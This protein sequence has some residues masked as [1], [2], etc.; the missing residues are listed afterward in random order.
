MRSAIDQLTDSGFT[1]VYVTEQNANS[2][3]D[4]WGKLPS[5][6]SS[7]ASYVMLQY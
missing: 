3:V 6:L 1:H 5:Y 2:T 7:E 4:V